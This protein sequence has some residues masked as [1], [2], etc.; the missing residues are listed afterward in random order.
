[1][2]AWVA[3]QGTL[4]VCCLDRVRVVDPDYTMADLLEDIN[5]RAIPPTFWEE[6]RAGMREA[7]DLQVAAEG[8]VPV[9][10]TDLIGSPR[11]GSR[12]SRRERRRTMRQRAPDH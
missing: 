8:K 9:P 4:Q 3:G 6:I 7:L 11:A 5:A 1:M 10:F 2:A 12:P